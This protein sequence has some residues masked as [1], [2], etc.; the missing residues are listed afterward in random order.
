MAARPAPRR[1]AA[2]D[3]I[4]VRAVEVLLGVVDALDDQ[5]EGEGS[6]VRMAE[7]M[8]RMLMA[9]IAWFP[10]PKV[11]GDVIVVAA[12]DRGVPVRHAVLARAEVVAWVVGLRGQAMALAKQCR[13]TAD[14]IVFVGVSGGIEAAIMERGREA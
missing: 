12:V 10:G 8:R 11:G 13:P 1:N 6:E 14:R 2:W 5:F 4:A 9:A 3:A 7:D